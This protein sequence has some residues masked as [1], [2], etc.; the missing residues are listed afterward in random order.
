MLAGFVPTAL[1]GFMLY[2]FIKHSLIGNTW[3]VIGALFVGGVA[4]IG[5]EIV[6][7]KSRQSNENATLQTNYREEISYRDA[8]IIGL[9]QSL[10]VIPGVSRSAATI[11]GG[12]VLGYSREKIVEFSFLLALPTM[13][14]AT[15]LD[16][17]KTGFSFTTREYGLLAVGFA[18][19][20]VIALVVI[21]WLLKFVKNHT[22]M[23]FGAY[24][25]VLALVC[26]ALLL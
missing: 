24:R 11:V 25:I 7:K 21:T 20:F 19:S 18:V 17:L 16:L 6:F 8:V 15:G 9:F 13:V 3:V 22:F 23:G 4:L 5:F 1:V 26:F 10:A 14:A 2:K 12:M